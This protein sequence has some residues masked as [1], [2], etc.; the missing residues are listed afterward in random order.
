SACFIRA[1]VER[2]SCF[3]RLSMDAISEVLKTVKLDSAFFFNAEFS[4]PWNFRS[5]ASSKLA[6]YLN[7]PSG[8]VIVYHLLT[9][10]KAYARLGDERLEILPG[11]VVIFP[12]GNAHVFESGGS[13]TAVNVAIGLQKVFSQGLRLSRMGGGGEITRFVC[14]FMVCEPALCQVFLASLPPMF[15]VNIRQEQAGEWLENSIRYSVGE[16]EAGG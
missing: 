4:A 15:K 14:G 6:P 13:S 5:P 8:H 1:S 11:E 9:S 10:G 7:Q 12:H 2:Q 16:T 3:A